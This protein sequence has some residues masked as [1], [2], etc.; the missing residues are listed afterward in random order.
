MAGNKDIIRHMKVSAFGDQ[1]S[2]SPTQ[3]VI[4]TF[5]YGVLEGIVASGLGGSGSVSS[6]SAGRYGRRV[7]ALRRIFARPR[8]P[9][10]N[11]RPGCVRSAFPALNGRVRVP[12]PLRVMADP[13]SG[14]GRSVE[15]RRPQ[16]PTGGPDGGSCDVRHSAE[17]SACRG[18]GPSRRHGGDVADFRR[19]GSCGEIIAECAVHCG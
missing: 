7:R 19:R 1:V 13:G 6:R 10:S 14:C 15:N 3:V 11:D 16:P 9:H 5:P 18:L 12:I 2:V 17:C 4:A 8:R